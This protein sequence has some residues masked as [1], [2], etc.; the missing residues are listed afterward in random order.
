[1]QSMTPTGSLVLDPVN[2]EEKE[3]KGGVILARMPSLNELTM[4]LMVGQMDPVPV[5]EV[6][7]LVDVLQLFIFLSFQSVELCIDGCDKLHA[8]MRDILIENT[9]GQQQQ[10]K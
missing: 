6:C 1:V 9:L 5:T 8:I 2:A 7:V 10:N 3:Q 4:I